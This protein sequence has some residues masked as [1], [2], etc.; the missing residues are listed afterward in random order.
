MATR[1]SST[2]AAARRAAMERA[3][4]F[5]EREQ[6]LVTLAVDHEQAQTELES[7]ADRYDEQVA[8]LRQQQADEERDARQRVAHCV[9]AMVDLGVSKDEA[10]ERLGI[11]RTALNEALRAARASAPTVSDATGSVSDDETA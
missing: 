10:A 6:Q 1:K 2:A 9:A 5:Q 3:A 8:K 4:R 7:V 11:T